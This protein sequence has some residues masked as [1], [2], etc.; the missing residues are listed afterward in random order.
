MNFIFLHPQKGEVA[1]SVRA[2]DSYPS[3]DGPEFRFLKV[4]VQ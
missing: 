3:V 4:K 1:Q 2:S